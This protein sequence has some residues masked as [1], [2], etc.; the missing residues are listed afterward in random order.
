VV[1]HKK[2]KFFKVGL[3]LFLVVA[4]GLIAVVG[5]GCGKKEAGKTEGD[6][7]GTGESADTE[8]PGKDVKVALVLPGPI[9]DGGWC[10]SAYEALMAGA[11]KY[12]VQTAYSENVAMA[13]FEETFRDYASKGYDLI[14]GHGFQFSDVALKVG[15][16]FPNSKFAVVNAAIEAPNVAGLEFSNEE[17]GYLVGALAGLM[18]KT[19]KIGFVG[20]LEIPSITGGANGYKAGAKAVNPDVEV[21]VSYAG[22]FEDV[23]KGKEMA[24]AQINN[25]A[26]VVFQ[27]ADAAGIGVIQAAQEKGVYAIGEPIDQRELAPDT[28]ISSAIENVSSL[29]GL[30]IEAVVTDTFKGEMFYGT[31]A[32]G[33]I[34]IGPYND[35]VPQE[36]RDKIAQ[37]RQDI[38]DGKIDVP[39]K[40]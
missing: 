38:I 6:A 39:K 1:P 4:V 3:V 19:N 12:G 28:V 22:S 31:V 23:A 27:F 18:T 16:E 11:E 9:S 40:Q 34:D 30:A 33:V 21:Y 5:A 7:G 29:V 37:I 10:A 15:E 24:L 26:D 32:N 25:G 14:I 17:A 20:G 13:D 36:V 35:K 8:S 2:H